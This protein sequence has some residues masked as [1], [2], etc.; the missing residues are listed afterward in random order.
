MGRQV[1]H[2]DLISTAVDD[3]ML[4]LTSAVQQQHS[5][6]NIKEIFQF[7]Q[8]GRPVQLHVS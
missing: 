5:L 3:R 4:T 8:V 2:V 6:C 7:Q 1:S